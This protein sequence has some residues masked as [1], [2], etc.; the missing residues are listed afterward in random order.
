M[1]S[2]LPVLPVLKY[3]IIS[4]TDFVLQGVEVLRPHSLGGTYEEVSVNELRTYRMTRRG[5][6][7]STVGG[8]RV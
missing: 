6:R 7:R 1:I 8:Q 4:F 3:T 2:V 5:R